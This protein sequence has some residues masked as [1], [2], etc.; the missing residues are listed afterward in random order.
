MALTNRDRVGKGFELLRD[1]LQP[2]VE[3]QMRGMFGAK[4]VERAVDVVDDRQAQ[5][6]RAGGEQ[7]VLVLLNIMTGH[8]QN[9]FSRTLGSSERTMIFELRTARNDWAHM[10]NFSTT[11]AFRAL[12]SVSR[13]LNAVSAGE[14]ADQAS[15]QALELLNYHREEAARKEVRRSVP[16]PASSGTHI[17]TGGPSAGLRGWRQVIQPH[18]DVATGSLSQAEFAADLGQ[19][20]A[21]QGRAEYTDPLEFFRR[22]YLTQGLTQLLTNALKRVAKGQGDPVVDLY[23]NFG[24]GKTHSM[25]A[26]YH[27]FSG[28]QT[29][30]LL[31]MEPILAAT[32]VKTAPKAKYAVLVGNKTSPAEAHT[33]PDGTVVRTF[34]GDLAWQI[35][36][37]SA[38]ALVAEPDRMG[39]SPGSDLLLTIFKGAGPCLILIDE[40][41]AYIRQLRHVTDL[42]AGSFDANIS[43]AQALT[44]AVKAAPYTLL[45]ASL[46]ASDIEIGGEGGKEA[47]SQLRNVFGRVESPWRAATSDEGFEIVRRRL[48]EPISDTRGLQTRD[49]V[50]RAFREYYEANRADFPAECR[51]LAYEKRIAAC[52][53]IHPEL[54]DR[55]YSDWSTLEKFQ[56]TRGVLRLMA[57][58]VHALW[59]AQDPSPLIMP[60]SIPFGVAE[61]QDELARFLDD[62]WTPIVDTEVDDA[63]ALPMKIDLAHQNLGRYGA[64]QRVARTIYLGSPPT[65]KNPTPGLND[66]QVKLGC[67]QPVEPVAI[68]GDAL[69][70]LTEESVHLNSE[71]KRYWYSI[72]PTLARLAQ[73]RAETLDDHLVEA[74][75]VARLRKEQSQRGSFAAV[76][77]CPATSGDVPDEM[78][79]RLVILSPSQTHA[80]GVES[81]A[82]AAALDIL[83]HRGASPRYNA[84]TLIFLVADEN[85]VK[86]LQDAVRLYLAWSAIVS[87]AEAQNLTPQQVRQAKERTKQ[88]DATITSRIPETYRWILAPEKPTSE[89]TIAMQVISRNGAGSDSLAKAVS[90]RLERDE[91]LI[92]RW[93]GSNLRMKLDQIP[94]WRGGNAVRVSQLAEDFASYLY[95]PRLCDTE[96]LLDAIRDGVSLM[97]WEREGFAYADSYDEAHGRYVGLRGGEQVIQVAL[98]GLVVRSDTA[99]A[100]MQAD[101]ARDKKDTQPLPAFIV[102]AP[103]GDGY[104]STATQTAP[105]IRE[106][107][108]SMPIVAQLPTRFHGSVRLDPARPGRD[109]EQIIRE[110]IQHLTSI[111]GSE[112]TLTLEIAAASE[113]GFGENTVRTVSEN[114]RTL[115]FSAFGFEEA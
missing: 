23:T 39:V 111:V 74:E 44:E 105:G 69:R 104:P 37:K 92:S 42:P 56:R 47:L 93:A 58:V 45:V 50:A 96:T 14:L 80:K 24:G 32:G 89:S 6:L 71:N 67:A 113:D 30:S 101:A 79:V 85:Q 9:V 109:A 114:C 108:A 66:L 68:F 90:L 40:W 95:L 15:A 3:A 83:A 81:R 94:L 51:D 21:G 62:N 1:G 55:L 59:R 26:L 53:P 77:I 29:A 115:K 18:E 106:Q 49:A 78:S 82:Q 97:T 41:L 25:L 38:Y 103:G 60:G 88:A 43:F 110:V 102:G 63:N 100:Q 36:G 57:K 12:D 84:N 7:D 76:H 46:P 27:L 65:Q 33:K 31:G 64:A 48:F 17:P 87:D 72:Q 8:W 98:S 22:T 34:W 99:L 86:P 28:V 54:F 91:L 2:F 20:A 11:D 13:L 5:R 70:K 4:W 107:P 10:E 16:L 52:Y 19:V 75:I 61:V 112:V 35:G 73:D